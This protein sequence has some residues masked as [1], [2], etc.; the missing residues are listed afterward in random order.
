MQNTRIQ[1]VESLMEAYDTEYNS[2]KPNS[3]PTSSAEVRTLDES[4]KHPRVELTKK[5]FIDKTISFQEYCEIEISKPEYFSFK[6][7]KHTGNKRIIEYTL[8]DVD[9]KY[10]RHEWIQM[11]LDKGVSIEDYKDYEEYLDIRINVFSNEYLVDHDADEFEQSV[12]IDKEIS[13]YQLIQEARRDNPEIEDWTVIGENALPSVP[14][15][16]YVCKIDSEYEIKSSKNRNSEP[17]LSEEQK[18]D[19]QNNGIEPEGWEVVYVDK[20]GNII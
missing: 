3:K 11:L 9:A 16:M 10:P 18:A 13:Q 7:D 5:M 14:G 17:K 19:L 1:T 2:Q 12:Y 6:T 15:R 8:G 20:N 4:T